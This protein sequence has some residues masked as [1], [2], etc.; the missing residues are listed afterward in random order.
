MNQ[1]RSSHLYLGGT[2]L[3][4]GDFYCLREVGGEQSAAVAVAAS[5]ASGDD[6]DE[7][8]DVGSQGEC[9]V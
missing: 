7:V 9:N 1:S 4:H 8:D 3:E 2:Q 6:D 5:P